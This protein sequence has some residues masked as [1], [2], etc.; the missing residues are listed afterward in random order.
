MTRTTRFVSLAAAAALALLGA[1][2]ATNGL[3][4]AQEL[5]LYRAHA[6]E[7]VKSFTFFGQLN[8]WAPLGDTAL[9][10]WTKPSEAYLLELPGRCVDL[11]TAPAITVTNQGSRVYAKFD[12]VLVLGGLH[13]SFRMP[14]RI[15]TIRP[16]DVKALRQAQKSLR[17][18]KAAERQA[19]AAA[20]TNH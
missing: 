9:A 19:G 6:G 18:A 4:D 12:D 14:C 20:P 8:G 5:D 13:N 3:T 17:E 16:L 7:P 1:G 10:V 15:D 11:D 2:C